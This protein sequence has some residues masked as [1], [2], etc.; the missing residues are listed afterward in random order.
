MQDRQKI[1]PSVSMKEESKLA[2][3][4]NTNVIFI[5]I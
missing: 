3:T 5:R 2:A 1:Q 4:S